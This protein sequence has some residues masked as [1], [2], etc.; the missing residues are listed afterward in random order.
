MKNLRIFFICFIFILSTEAF[1]EIGS[2]FEKGG[3]GFSGY[4]SFFLDLNTFLD[5]QNEKFYYQ[6]DIRPEIIFFLARNISLSLGPS[7]YYEEKRKDYENDEREFRFGLFGGF[8]YFLVFNP[9]SESGF[10][11]SL[12]IYLNITFIPDTS[13]RPDEYENDDYY[14]DNNK[15]LTLVLNLDPGIKLLYFIN[16]SVAPFVSIY[17]SIGYLI[18]ETDYYGNPLKRSLAERL[19]LRLKILFG[20]SIHIPVEKKSIL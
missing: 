7:L 2:N 17:P 9:E 1:A 4:L 5:D 18:S 16:D 3:I 15:S 20:I 19:K 14:D 13:E 10:V 12:S 11:S 6:A 8:S